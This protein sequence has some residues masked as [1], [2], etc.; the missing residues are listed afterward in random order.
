MPTRS[1]REEFPATNDHTLHGSAAVAAVE[2]WSS[3]RT[4]ARAL[5][6]VPDTWP[7]SA[8]EV[9]HLLGVSERTIRR[10]ISRGE[11]AA[12]KRGGAFQIGVT[13]LA[14]Y[15]MARDRR[16][17]RGGAPLRIVAPEA[18]RSLFPV[19][20]STLVGR[21]VEITAVDELLRQ[22]A[23]R[24]LTLTGPGGVGKTRL[25]I[26]VAGRM[27]APADGIWFVG[28]AAI[29]RPEL[30]LPTIA[31]TLGLQEAGDQSLTARLRRY[32]RDRSLFLVL[33]NLE[34]LLAAGPQLA[35]LLT[36]CPRL[37]ILA[38][39][40]GPLRIQGEQEYAVPP[41]PLPAPNGQA[42]V[43]A[44][45]TV[46]AIRL[47]V[48]RARSVKP[49]FTLHAANA[50]SVAAI[51]KRLDGLPLAIELAAA[52]IALLSPAALLA[53]LDRQLPV[54]T[55]GPRDQPARLKT[56]RDAIAWS[57]D[58]LSAEEQI[59]FRRLAVFVG[60]APLDAVERFGV[61][62]GQS[63]DVTLEA[64]SS[65]VRQSLLLAEEVA[66]GAARSDLN[67]VRML[68]PIR[69][70]A[71]EQLTVSGEGERVRAAHATWCLELVDAS[72]PHWFTANQLVW[73]ER[74]EPEHG[75]VRAALAWFA[76]TGDAPA[77]LRMCAVVWRF[78]F[79]RSHYAEGQAWLEKALA[80]STGERTRERAWALNGAAS[81]AVFQADPRAIAWCEESFAISQEIGFQFGAANAQLVLGHVA[82]LHGDYERA[83]RCQE[84]ALTL[85]REI[86]DAMPIATAS[87]STVLG[88]L[89]EIAVNQGEY[90]RAARLAE[91]ALAIQRE[92]GWGW[93]AAQ[94][95]H[96]LASIARHQGDAH[97]ALGLYQ[98]SLD[99]AWDERDQRLILRSLDYL[100]GLAAEAG[101]HPRASRLFGAA[102]RL[103]ELLGTPLD[104]ADQ[105]SYDRAL[106]VTR[107]LLGATAFDA[108]WSAGWSL[109]LPDLVAEAGR[110]VDDGADVHKD[111]AARFGL[112][113]RERDVLRL[114]V[115]GQSDRQI[116]Q[117]LFIGRRTV[118][119]H[120]SSILNKLELES[121]TAVAAY[122]IQH[123]LV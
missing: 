103:R 6:G 121:R 41:L 69:D 35:D 50:A 13:E 49:A 26:E 57:H 101:E 36:S 74:L 14:R 9:A 25:A 98:Q 83:N 88:N 77:L 123:R 89:A 40:R 16:R 116:A 52:R 20:L 82:L 94:S 76:Q 33:D 64:L 119:S 34:H 18:D 79:L 44:L 1:Q 86:G 85:M 113:R 118:E 87:A 75:N 96:T 15:Q 71:R 12:T 55:D 102:A 80:G 53:R 95:L 68:E 46:D 7:R 48:E 112:T 105:H 29:Q 70:F 47:F 4:D 92:I 11:L 30:V 67:R 59:L 42:T 3:D 61:A 110:P 97:R 63:E 38:T 91:E 31:L 45:A 62:L 60:G 117:T 114:L 106:T 100:A 84:A 115:A 23:T 54:L 66:S 22:P 56:M 27:V 104:P 78:W 58:L 8:I 19:P 51:C 107:A 108:S 43:E 2:E 37:K 93:G 109:S 122:V 111:A 72:E 90:A 65:L 5:S 17:R 24:L 28:L 39:S 81:I 21:E 73:A 120:V 99:Q 32:L 10:A